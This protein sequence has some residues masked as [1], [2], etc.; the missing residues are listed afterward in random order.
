MQAEGNQPGCGGPPG[1]WPL[2]MAEAEG[3]PKPKGLKPA[4]AAEETPK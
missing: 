2:R 4:W 3:W 1:V